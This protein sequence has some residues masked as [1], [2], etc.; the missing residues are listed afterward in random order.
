VCVCVCER[1]RGNGFENWKA[2][3]DKFYIS[4]S[5]SET[6]RESWGKI[7]C[8]INHVYPVKVVDIVLYTLDKFTLNLQKLIRHMQSNLYVEVVKLLLSYL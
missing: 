7:W 6:E 3:R 2:V 8:D 4:E 1:E 5:V